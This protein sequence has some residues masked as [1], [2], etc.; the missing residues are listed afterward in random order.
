LEKN[1]TVQ[2]IRHRLLCPGRGPGNWNG[3][4]T[5]ADNRLSH[6]SLFKCFRFL[7]KSQTLTVSE[8]N[9]IGH[10]RQTQVKELDSGRNAT[11]AVPH[12]TKMRSAG[13]LM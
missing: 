7:I 8:F 2:V 1:A 10:H 11:R 12:Q 3:D 9:Q 6:R 13:K 4:P 5:S